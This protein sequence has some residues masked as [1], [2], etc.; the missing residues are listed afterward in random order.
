MLNISNILLRANGQG[1]PTSKPKLRQVAVDS[2]HGDMVGFD[3]KNKEL[4]RFHK[5]RVDGLD[6]DSIMVICFTWP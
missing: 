3:H 6:R 5:C 4:N 1:L 2:L